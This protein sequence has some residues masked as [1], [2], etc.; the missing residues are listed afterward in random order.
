MRRVETAPQPPVRD[1]AYYH[2]VLA[3]VQ[4]PAA[5]IDLDALTINLQCLGKRA[6]HLP[7]R[8]VTKSIRSVEMIR[9]IM[10]TGS[11]MQGLLCYSAA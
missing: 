3:G 9:T 6:G 7:V 2:Q 4:L 10:A 11:F 1:Y 8:L 5:L